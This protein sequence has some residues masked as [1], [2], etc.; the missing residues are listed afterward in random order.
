MYRVLVCDKISDEGVKLLTLEQDF[1]VDVKTG[2]KEDELVAIIENYDA[3]IVR[4]AT[5]SPAGS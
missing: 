1:E 5:K 2:L 3:M 4:S